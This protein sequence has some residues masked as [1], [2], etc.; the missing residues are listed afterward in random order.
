[1]TKKQK[2]LTFIFIVIGAA[3]MIF[4]GM[5][6]I[7]SVMRMRGAGPFGKPPP[8]DQTDIALIRDW[9]TVPYVA[10]MYNVPPDALFKS[11][12][13]ADRENRKK[14]LKEL[15][16]E[17]YPDQSGVILAHVQAAVQSMQKQEPPPHFPATPRP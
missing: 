10:R 1:M 7:R 9:M 13:L 14:S 4:F 5:R 11:L 16:D 3:A 6:A 12:G 8:A 17:F 2:I 15:N